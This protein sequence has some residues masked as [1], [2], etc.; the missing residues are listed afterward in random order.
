MGKHSKGESR[1]EL[2]FCS[3]AARV[4]A[5]SIGSVYSDKGPACQDITG[6][7]RPANRCIYRKVRLFNEMKVLN[8]VGPVGDFLVV[9]ETKDESLAACLTAMVALMSITRPVAGVRSGCIS[10]RPKIRDCC[11]QS[12]MWTRGPLLILLGRAILTALTTVLHGCQK[13]PFLGCTRPLAK[14]RGPLL[15]LAA[16][17]SG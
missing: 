8:D 1:Q 13:V 5:N 7:L 4:V 15:V 3:E 11:M 6:M 9:D 2:V 17:S 16:P 10:R 12:R 14:I